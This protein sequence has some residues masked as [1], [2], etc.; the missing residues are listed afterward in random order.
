MNRY[1]VLWASLLKLSWKQRP[2]FLTLFLFCQVLD[3]AALAFTGLALRDAIDAAQRGVLA[4]SIIAATTAAVCYAA[5]SVLR[6]VAQTLRLQA[7][8]RIGVAELDTLIMRYI[9]GVEGIEHLERPQFLD[10]ITVLRGAGWGVMDSTWGVVEAV[11][12]TVRLAVLLLLLNTVDPWLL[13]LLPF[14]A[15]PLWLDKRGQGAV[16]K[17]EVATAEAM[18]LQKHLFTL[19]T[20]AGPGKELRITS[21]GGELARRQTAAW[22]EAVEARFRAQ[23]ASAGWKLCGW[24]IFMLG[25]AAALAFVVRQALTAGGSA[26]DIVLTVTVATTLRSAVQQTVSR[27]AEVASY[28]RL[29]DPFLWLRDY[30]AREKAA[31]PVTGVPVPRRIEK[32]IAFDRVSYMY[33]GTKHPAVDEVTIDLPAGSVVAVVGEYGSGK[34]TLVKLLCKYYRPDEGKITVDGNDLTSLNAADWWERL[35]VAFQDF[36]RY[37][38]TFGEAVG[39]GDLP[40]KDDSDRILAAL[41]AADAEHLPSRLV[42]GL[43]TQLGKEFGGTDLSEGQWQKTALARASMREAPVMVVLDEP[44]ASLDAPSEQTVFE[45]YMRNARDLAQKTGAVTVVVSHRFSTVAGADL[46]LVMRRGRLVEHGSHEELMALGGSYA[47]LYSIQEK[48]Y[49]LPQS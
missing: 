31:R 27:S 10:R 17:A 20:T 12:S 44:T 41:R 4:S 40:N 48:A 9:V 34:T 47:E 21:A 46:I 43:R 22:D 19:L 23:L 16:A 14:A 42:N 30:V 32:G 6:G 33:P 13:T 49:S 24:V 35:S 26:G 8:E 39:L 1:L 18:R 25:Y 7:I 37:R 3:I 5:T 38:T 29:L 45:T 2:G 15:V 28:K 36:G 11:L